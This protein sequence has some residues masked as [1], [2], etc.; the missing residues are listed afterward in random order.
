MNGYGFN[1]LKNNRLQEGKKIVK[2]GVYQSKSPHYA[3]RPYL[4]IPLSPYLYIPLSQP[5]TCR[6]TAYWV[7]DCN[8]FLLILER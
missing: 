4:L 2:Y 3:D 5:A 7:F 6:K 8:G 1:R